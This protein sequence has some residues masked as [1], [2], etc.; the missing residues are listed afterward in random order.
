[1]IIFRSRNETK[2]FLQNDPNK[3]VGQRNPGIREQNPKCAKVAASRKRIRLGNRCSGL[4]L[5]F[6]ERHLPDHF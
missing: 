4:Q 2:C 6:T 1:M 3:V 5:H